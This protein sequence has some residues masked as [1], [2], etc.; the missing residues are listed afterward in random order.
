LV[1]FQILSDKRRILLSPFFCIVLSEMIYREA[2]K[3]TIAISKGAE[4]KLD[5]W[6]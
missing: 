6:Q 2:P 4:V 3:V 1:F 5:V